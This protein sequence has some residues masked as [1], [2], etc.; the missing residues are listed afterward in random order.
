MRRENLMKWVPT[1]VLAC[2]VLVVF[3]HEANA[4]NSQVRSDGSLG[5]GGTTTNEIIRRLDPATTQEVTDLCAQSS[6]EATGATAG[7]RFVSDNSRCLRETK[8]EVGRRRLACLQ[9]AVQEKRKDYS[10]DRLDD[11]TRNGV[12][13][14]TF[15]VALRL[16]ADVYAIER[17]AP[18]LTALLDLADKYSGAAGTQDIYNKVLSRLSSHCE[19]LTLS[20]DSLPQWDGFLDTYQAA[21][22]SSG[23]AAALTK[24]RAARDAIAARIEQLFLNILRTDSVATVTVDELDA[25]YAKEPLFARSLTTDAHL[26]AAIN[27][28]R[29]DLSKIIV[30]NYTAEAGARERFLQFLRVEGTYDDM[31]AL[32]QSGDVLARRRALQLAT[33]DT[34]RQAVRNIETSM[35]I[36]DLQDAIAEKNVS[37]A[38]KVRTAIRNREGYTTRDDLAYINFVVT[39]G[40]FTDVMELFPENP[41]TLLGRAYDLAQTASEKNAVELEVVK[42]LANKL[43]VMA[44][45]LD[46]TGR[47]RSSDTD[48]I[49]GRKIGSEITSALRYSGRVDRAM[50]GPSQDYSVKGTVTLHI[51]GKE[52]GEKV[53]G[54][55]G[56]SKCEYKDEPYSESVKVPVTLTFTKGNSYQTTGVETIKWD[57]VSGGSGLASGRYFGGTRIRKADDLSMTFSLDSVEKM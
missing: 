1:M 4:Q 15:N 28:K 50:F 6:L 27:A 12:D 38:R 25:A 49:I 42:L 36:S 10:D 18:S 54:F 48:M 41:R 29:V 34:L 9:K 21:S 3:D 57:A 37:Y 2:T 22:K 53:C 7:E 8:L 46:G 52:N 33:S 13:A 24:A 17:G 30:R 51:R 11:C 14:A 32:A 5:T 55:L 47:T 19:G 39:H 45:V 23:C 20:F 26:F 35:S 16:R 44:F 43:F 56:M 31:L 40:A